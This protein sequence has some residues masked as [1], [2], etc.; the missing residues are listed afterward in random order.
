MI[1]LIILLLVTFPIIY[2]VNKQIEITLCM[3][4]IVLILA[5]LNTPKYYYLI[6]KQLTKKYE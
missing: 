4:P 2:E 6:F 5:T 1:L 3:F